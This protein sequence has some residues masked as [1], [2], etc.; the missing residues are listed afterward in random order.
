MTFRTIWLRRLDELREDVRRVHRLL[1]DEVQAAARRERFDP[2]EAV[3]EVMTAP[4]EEETED[5]G[6]SSVLVATFRGSVPRVGEAIWTD[7]GAWKVVD[8]AWWVR[9]IPGRSGVSRA[10]VYVEPLRDGSRPN[11]GC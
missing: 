11:R 10:C 1:F 9:S 8:V 5:G 4:A 3:H 7:D 6:D 2:L